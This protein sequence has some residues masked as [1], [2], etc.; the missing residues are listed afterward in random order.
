MELWL[1]W[2]VVKRRWWLIGLPVLVTL[3]YAAYSIWRHPPSGS[4]N[5]TLRFTAAQPPD[6]PVDNYED[7]RYYPWLASEYVVNALADWVRTSTFA[8][9]LSTEIA[10]QDLNIPAGVLRGG[11]AADNERSILILYLSWGDSTQLETIAQAAITVLSE[12]TGAY[13]PQLGDQG[14]TVIPLDE[15]AVVPVPPPLTARLNPMMRVGFGLAAGFALA[16]LVEY[17]DSTVRNRQELEQLGLAVLAEIP[18]RKIG[19]R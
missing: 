15:P 14:A 13:F 2:K 16:F 10:Q 6:E 1:L 5:V 7:E 19:N 9:E 17:L 11:I 12:R 8:E 4:Y 3:V 18:R